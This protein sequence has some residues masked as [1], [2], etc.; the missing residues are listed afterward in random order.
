MAEILTNRLTINATFSS[1]SSRSSPMFLGGLVGGDDGGIPPKGFGSLERP[2]SSN[3]DRWN[4]VTKRRPYRVLCGPGH[5]KQRRA[6][7][8]IEGWRRSEWFSDNATGN[9]GATNLAWRQRTST[10][11]TSKGAAVTAGAAGFSGGLGSDET[12]RFSGIQAQRTTVAAGAACF[13][14]GLGVYG[15]EK[16]NRR[17]GG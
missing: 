11:S 9:S 2:I 6:S 17:E 7:A 3:G 8:S 16:R 12:A 1:L 15:T 14:G 4:L 5:R 10:A 13:Y